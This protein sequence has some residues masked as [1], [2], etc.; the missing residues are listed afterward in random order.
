MT[1]SR[2]ER[3]ARTEAKAA[4]RNQEYRRMSYWGENPTIPGQSRTKSPWDCGKTGCH[5]G[6]YPRPQ[7]EWSWEGR[8]PEWVW[9]HPEDVPETPHRRRGARRKTYRLEYRSCRRNGSWSYWTLYYGRYASLRDARNAV[10]QL[11]KNHNHSWFRQEYRLAP[12]NR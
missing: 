2:G 11:N 10:A 4:R 9:E 8:R 1:T 7:P 12:E 6:G 5:C 3:R